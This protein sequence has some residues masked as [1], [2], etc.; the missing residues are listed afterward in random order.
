MLDPT[1]VD[2]DDDFT[3]Y[4]ALDKDIDD[5]L[6]KRKR[7][8]E[9]V[10]R[11]FRKRWDSEYLLDLANKEGS[12]L[13]EYRLNPTSF[14]LLHDILEPALSGN[15]EMARRASSG[16]SDPISSESR[17]GIALIMLG[18]GRHVEAMRTHGVARATVYDTFHKVIHA[19]NTNPALALT[20]NHSKVQLEQRAEG[21]RK[22]S[23]HG[24]FQF[25][26]GCLDG[27]AIHIKAPTQ[28]ANQARYWSNSKKKYAINMQGVCDADCRFIAF[29][30]KH[31]GGTN[32]APAF[33]NSNLVKICLS[34]LFPYHWN[35]DNA[36]TLTETNMVPFPGV[37][38][39]VTHPEQE[40]FN[41]WHSQLRITIERTFGIFIRRWGI[42][43]HALDFDVEF[44]IQIIHACVRLHNFCMNAGLDIL[45][46][47][48]K[49]PSHVSV[50][51]NGVLED[52][53]WP[54]REVEHE[55]W[56]LNQPNTGS[57]LR[58]YLVQEIADN[59]YYH[60]R[61]HNLS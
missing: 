27:L 54:W 6:K 48:Y 29:S 36:Y 24:L 5:L 55:E 46:D 57:T 53:E 12:F 9:R 37:N 42:F 25:C 60:V 10:P 3:E 1:D 61:S 28:Q 44:C 19:I 14:H 30:A 52:G 2:C 38:L 39:H 41:F 22:R 7:R 35:S 32:D 56:Q 23:T 33:E 4:E 45:P 31:P 58:D 20:D 43:W 40:A 49:Q 8:G 59:Q 51:R 17:L 11:L 21:F 18:G 15:V 50:D 26:S 13:A 47:K 34:Q 16:Q